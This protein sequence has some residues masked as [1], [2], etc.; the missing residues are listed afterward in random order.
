MQCEA[1]DLGW[2]DDAGLDQI[3]ELASFRVET[4]VFILR[5]AHAAHDHGAFV[6]GVLGDLP[7]RLLKSTPDDIDADGLIPVD[8]EFLQGRQAAQ[9]RG[10]PPVNDAFLTRR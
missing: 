9:K 5:F 2:V 8:L 7:R 4:E 1:G 3:A 10:T 6:P